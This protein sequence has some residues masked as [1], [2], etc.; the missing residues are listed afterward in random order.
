[1]GLGIT[2]RAFVLPA[3][4]IRLCAVHA[5]PGRSLGSHFEQAT[6]TKVL[7]IGS[8]PAEVAQFRENQATTAG[9]DAF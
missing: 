7:K 8:K 5:V 3:V 9:S 4:E 6:S 2:F 1:M